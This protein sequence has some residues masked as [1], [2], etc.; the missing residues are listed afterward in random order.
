MNELF[1]LI[2]SLLQNIQNIFYAVY[3]YQ[4]NTTIINKRQYGL[5]QISCFFDL[6]WLD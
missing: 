4:F 1:L 6:G 3:I 2:T 5:F